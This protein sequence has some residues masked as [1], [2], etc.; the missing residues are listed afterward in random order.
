MWLA[1]PPPAEPRGESWSSPA[2]NLPPGSGNQSATQIDN[3]VIIQVV[4]ID[5]QGHANSALSPW[6]A[7]CRA[8]ETG[9]KTISVTIL[10]INNEAHLLSWAE[11]CKALSMDFILVLM[12]TREASSERSLA[13]GRTA[14]L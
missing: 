2:R 13:Q 14:E 9:N 5:A 8:W 3:E 1:P 12:K 11:T 10:L 7:H 4:T 6:G